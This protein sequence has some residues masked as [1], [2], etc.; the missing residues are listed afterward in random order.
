MKIL[1]TNFLKCAVK[2]CDKSNDNFPLR[3]SGS[4]CELVQDPSIEFNEE[5]M[6]NI[7]DRIDWDAVLSVAGDLGNT[8]L[9]STKPLLN[10]AE[11][12]SED[13]LAVLRDL[14]VLLVQ[15]SI[16]EGTMTCRN[17]GHVY[18][19]KNSIPNL[20]LPPHLA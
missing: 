16:K 15:T 13:D 7:M 17:C 2:A 1:T 8:N 10:T 12:L 9:P 14:H 5:F 6:T 19:I 4:E 18:Y 3:Y 20:L 11:Q